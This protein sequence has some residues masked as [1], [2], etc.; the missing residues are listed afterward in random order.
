LTR[1][2]FDVAGIR[3]RDRDFADLL[4]QCQLGAVVDEGGA[5][6]VSARIREE[7]P[8]FGWEVALN[9]T[10]AGEAVVHL[11]DCD[12]VEP[13]QQ[14]GDKAV[15]VVAALLLGVPQIGNVP[16][17][18]KEAIGCLVRYVTADLGRLIPVKRTN[19]SVGVVVVFEV[20]LLEWRHRFQ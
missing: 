8:V 19:L 12:E 9:R 20:R 15:V 10:Q 3:G 18:E 14:L 1:R 4:Q 13:A 5:F 7:E 11:L 2:K 16:G 6:V 17:C